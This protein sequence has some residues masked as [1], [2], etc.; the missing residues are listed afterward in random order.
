MHRSLTIILAVVVCIGVGA[1]S[2]NAQSTP[3]VSTTTT[4]MSRPAS[5]FS[6]EDL[7]GMT[8]VDATSEAQRQNYTVRVVERDG[9]SMVVTMDYSDRRINLTIVDGVVTRTTIG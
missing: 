5:S 8:E 9:E 2:S 1:C 4:T 3:D 7:I 6:P